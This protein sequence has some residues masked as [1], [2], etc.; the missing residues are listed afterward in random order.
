MLE[1]KD[2]DYQ[3]TGSTSG[4]PLATQNTPDGLPPS[5]LPAQQT[6]NHLQGLPAY[7]HN[8]YNNYPTLPVS[9]TLTEALP[10]RFINF[11]DFPP[12]LSN[13]SARRNVDSR[14]FLRVLLFINADDV[15]RGA[16]CCKL[17]DS[18]FGSAVGLT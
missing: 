12:V 10:A 11:P 4:T 13:G 15:P 5:S 16:A 18:S 7:S 8:D 1:M 17:Y 9:T 3:L 6:N 2:S 14:F